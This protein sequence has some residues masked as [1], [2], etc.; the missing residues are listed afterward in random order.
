MSQKRTDCSHPVN[1]EAAPSASIMIL[2][3]NGKRF[4]EKCLRTLED[5]QCPHTE[6]ILVDNG[7]TDESV[8]FVRE[9]YPWVK[10]VAHEDNLGYSSGYNR[11]APFAR[12]KI[13]VFLNQ[14]TWVERG[15]LSHLVNPLLTDLDI[16]MTTS[17]LILGNTGLIDSVGGYLK[18]WT[19]GGPLWAGK[20]SSEV[21]AE[22]VIPFY[23]TGAAMA[24]RS[25]IF[26][27]LGGF[28]EGMPAF[29]EDLDLSWRVRLNG[30][31]IVGVPESI[32]HHHLSGSW[33][34]FNP[35][36][37]RMVT[38][39]QLRAMMKCLSF[40]HLLHAF[41]AYA[42]LNLLKGV[43]L[44][45]TEHRMEF[46]LAAYRGLVDVLQNLEEIRHL[47]REVQS[48]RQY[49]DHLVLR[50]E[51]FGLF[52]TPSQLATRFKLDQHREEFLDSEEDQRATESAP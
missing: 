9:K 30:Y 32:I 43:I 17:R 33:G 2:S 27:D 49:P 34:Y 13:L 24:I 31:Q 23:A 39:H 10:I 28:D 46:V 22:R 7:S 12:G 51:E 42:L 41:P 47:R 5:D 48:R 15:W 8:P 26:H 44:S 21:E 18:L 3:W 1:W 52:D 37:V 35:A 20:P 40:K 50:S 19:G 36:K 45:V 29:A 4:L 16:G 38:G 6:I 11:A 25:S 14:D